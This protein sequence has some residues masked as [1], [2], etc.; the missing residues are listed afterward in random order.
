M[1]EKNPKSGS[2]GWKLILFY[3]EWKKT[4]EKFAIENWIN[5]VYPQPQLS[6]SELVQPLYGQFIYI[7]YCCCSIVVP[8]TYG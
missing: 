1:E 4:T 6:Y 2:K 7:F 5:E 3:V 8:F